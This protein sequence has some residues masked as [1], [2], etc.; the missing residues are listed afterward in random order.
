LNLLVIL[1]SRKPE[2]EAAALLQAVKVYASTKQLREELDSLGNTKG[3]AIPTV[4][5]KLC[6]TKCSETKYLKNRR[7]PIL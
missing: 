5:T 2:E 6:C 4:G 3:F 1:P 7:Q